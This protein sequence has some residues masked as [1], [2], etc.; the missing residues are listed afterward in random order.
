MS[1]DVDLLQKVITV[2]CL[3]QIGRRYRQRLIVKREYT[4]GPSP[5][6]TIMILFFGQQSC[7][8]SQ[9]CSTCEQ[10]NVG[11]EGYWLFIW[12]FVGERG[13]LFTSWCLFS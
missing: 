7:W 5:Q 13:G 3:S 2:N 4:C 10:Q 12:L 8:V 6:M 9:M 11:A 1:L